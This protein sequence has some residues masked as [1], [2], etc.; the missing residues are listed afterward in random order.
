MSGSGT[1]A[2]IYDYKVLYEKL[3]KYLRIIVIEKFGYGYSD[4]YESSCDIDTLVDIEKQVLETIGEKG[5]Y[6]LAAYSA[7]GLEAIRWK[8]K[9]PDDVMTIVGIDMANPLTYKNWTSDKI[10]KRM[11]LFN[12]KC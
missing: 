8:Q 5:P 1:V 4:I 12:K 11:K 2:P 6:I 10:E 7:L 9:Y 3:L